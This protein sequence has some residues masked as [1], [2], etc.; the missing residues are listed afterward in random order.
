MK[1]KVPCIDCI[2]LPSCRYKYYLILFSKCRIIDDF[3]EESYKAD[4]RS[5]EKLLRLYFALKPVTWQLGTYYVD[6]FNHEEKLLVVEP[7]QGADVPKLILDYPHFR[8]RNNEYLL[9]M[10][11]KYND[12]K[13]T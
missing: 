1:A 11:E 3:L 10:L 6:E 13:R 7:S 8:L 5:Q 12:K 4:K 9:K 2:C